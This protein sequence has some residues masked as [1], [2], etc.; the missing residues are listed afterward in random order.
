M[1]VADIAGLSREAGQHLTA[2][3]KLSKVSMY[4]LITFARFQGIARRGDTVA[5]PRNGPGVL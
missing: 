2:V 4:K 3:K 5:M 1:V